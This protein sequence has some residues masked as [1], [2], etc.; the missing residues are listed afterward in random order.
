MVKT[1]DEDALAD[2]LQ[3]QPVVVVINAEPLE[4]YQGG[5]FHGPCNAT[6]DHTVLLV[7]DGNTT[8]NEAYWKVRNSWGASWGMGGYA[9]L[10]RG[11]GGAGEC[12]IYVQPFYPKFPNAL[13][14]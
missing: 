10:S 8:S 14:V 13:V 7:G 9:L 3:L 12:G 1:D 2:A 5:V 4:M 11:V 6:V